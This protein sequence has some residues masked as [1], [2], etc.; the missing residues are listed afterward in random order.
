M[1]DSLY[2]RVE[3][4]RETPKHLARNAL[5]CVLQHFVTHQTVLVST[6]T[7]IFPPICTWAAATPHRLKF[8]HNSSSFRAGQIK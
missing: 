8:A 2:F 5:Q 1:V 3:N 7:R 6:G 4:R